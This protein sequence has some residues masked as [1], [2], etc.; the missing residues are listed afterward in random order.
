MRQPP[1]DSQSERAIIN[2][3]NEVSKGHTSLV[4]AHR[5]S[6]IVD[7]DNIIV[8]HQGEKVE[9]AITASCWPL[10]VITRPCG[11]PNKSSRKKPTLPE[12]E[13]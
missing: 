11:T 13:E 3:I 5:L 4:I 6:T 9:K 7:A 8:M 1:L 12:S 10:A 2:A